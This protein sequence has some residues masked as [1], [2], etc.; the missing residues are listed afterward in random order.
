MEDHNRLISDLAAGIEVTL[1]FCDRQHEYT[2]D[3]IRNILITKEL[4]KYHD[5]FRPMIR[6]E[7][8]NIIFPAGGEGLAILVPPEELVNGDISLKKN[9][10]PTKVDVKVN[11]PAVF[12]TE[13]DEE[14]DYVMSMN[15]VVQLIHLTKDFAAMMTGDEDLNLNV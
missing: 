13:V 14:R 7:R 4:E 5:L 15:D 8:G 6:R 3:L 12:N 2:H 10:D 9:E 11:L 1:G